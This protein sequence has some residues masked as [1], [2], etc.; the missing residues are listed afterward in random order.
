MSETLAPPAPETQTDLPAPE[1]AGLSAEA[2]AQAEQA[3]DLVIRIKMLGPFRCSA[4]I[5][6]HLGLAPGSLGPDTLKEIER[7][8]RKGDT[9]RGSTYVERG[10]VYGCT[11]GRT[12]L[13]YKVRYDYLGRDDRPPPARN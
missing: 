13:G 5:H 10:F 1:P 6:D 3:F 4:A 7:A 8:C 9:G 12:E 2:V 11:L